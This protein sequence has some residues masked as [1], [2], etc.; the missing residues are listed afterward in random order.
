MIIKT[1]KHFIITSI[2]TFACASVVSTILICIGAFIF[3]DFTSILGI[4][5][6][7]LFWRILLVVSLTLGGIFTSAI[8]QEGDDNV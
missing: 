7:A 6:C 8:L 4:L 1:I 5:R 2:I 3:W